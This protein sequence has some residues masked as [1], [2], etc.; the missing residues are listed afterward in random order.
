MQPTLIKL[1]NIRN[2]ENKLIM[3]SLLKLGR[4]LEKVEGSKNKNKN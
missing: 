2:I 1:N 3:Y 4:K